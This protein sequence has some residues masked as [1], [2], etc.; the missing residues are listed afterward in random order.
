MIKAHYYGSDGSVLGSVKFDADR[1]R[2]P[3]D[4]KKIYDAAPE[5][6]TVCKWDHGEV[7]PMRKKRSVEVVESLE[8][9]ENDADDISE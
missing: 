7:F 2:Q 6:W 5:D 3:L 4:I 9:H 1:N 8:I